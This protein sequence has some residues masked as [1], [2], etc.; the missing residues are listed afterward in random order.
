MRYDIHAHM[1]NTSSGEIITPHMLVES[2]DRYG[3][4]KVGISSLSGIDNRKQN[5]L[6][7]FAMDSFPERIRG[8]AFINPKSESVHD[9]IDLC[10]KEYKMSG[11]K[12]HPWKH[13]YFSDN[14]K[15]IYNVLEHIAQYDVHVQV[16]VGMSPIATP[17]PWIRYAKDFRNIKFLFTHMGD[18][19]FGYST[20][21][22]VKN[23]ENIYLETSVQYEVENLKLAK[24]SIGANRI[25]FGTDW[26]YKSVECEIQKI[27]NMG[28]T[29]EQLESVFYKNAKLLWNEN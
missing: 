28:F 5:D 15:Q 22:A 23:I 3:I 17:F 16:H 10:L 6:V 1:G 26:P 8:Y 9:E 24:D 11:V 4:D 13:G 14:T 12:F 2:M 29:Q 27:Y 20:I 19:D 18:R 25:C 21:K 7:K